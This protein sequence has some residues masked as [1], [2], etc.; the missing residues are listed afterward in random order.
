MIPTCS[1]KP[2][3]CRDLIGRLLWL[4]PA[5]I[6]VSPLFKSLILLSSSPE[7]PLALRT[8]ALAASLAFF[9]SKV[10][11]VRYLPT[12]RP[13]VGAVAFVISC[14]LVHNELRAGMA[15]E[16][17]PVVAAII[18]TASGVALAKAARRLNRLARVLTDATDAS[19]SRPPRVLLGLVEDVVVL[20]PVLTTMP[21]CVPR[22]PPR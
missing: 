19:L 18:A 6:H 15:E 11:G 12:S 20:L 21:S 17:E 13:W 9:V 3:S 14:G 22:G 2:H 4:V 1:I 16:A 10:L 5:V 7:L 8:S